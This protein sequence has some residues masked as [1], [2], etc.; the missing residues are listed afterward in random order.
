MA[1][2]TIKDIAEATNMSPGTVH[3]ALNGKK[4]VS[5][6]VRE[7][8]LS[9][10]DKLG[11]KPNY[12]ASSLKRKP[13]NILVALPSPVGSN[14]YFYTRLWQGVRRII[15]EYKDYNIN[16]IEL[17]YISDK[18]EVLENFL[19]EFDDEIDGLLTDANLG[20][21]NEHM[22]LKL[23]ND[24]IPTALVVDDLENTDRLCF[25]GANHLSCGKLLV[26]LLSTQINN[27]SDILVFCGNENTPSH[28]LCVH[29]MEQ[30][31]L[32]NNLSFNLIKIF[33]DENVKYMKEIATNEILNN[34]NLKAIYSVNAKNTVLLCNL[35]KTLNYDK[36]IRVIGSDVFEESIKFMEEGLLNNILQ[37]SP[38]N[39]SYLATKMLID[40][41]VKKEVPIKKVNFSNT[42]IVF[43]SNLQ[44][45]KTNKRKSD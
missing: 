35:L 5:V 20:Y 1:R 27:E 28:K 16:F 25:V 11:Y 4:G 8:I 33:N 23:L 19:N 17:S 42:N 38:E 18:N 13:L 14:K 44:Y 2:V 43:K 34:K 9:V 6:E 36:T 37:K 30:Y 10:A 45:Y 15:K 3:R 29:G 26:E 21:D 40:Y 39:Q 32:E 7:N 31:I 22:I 24:K 41:I 12:V